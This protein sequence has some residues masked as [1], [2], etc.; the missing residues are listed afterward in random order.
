M[1]EPLVPAVEGPLRPLLPLLPAV[2]EPVALSRPDEDGRRPLE[3]SGSDEPA[4]AEAPPALDPD[5]KELDELEDDEDEDE[6][7]EED[8]LEDADG[9][10]GVGMLV[11]DCVC[12]VDSQALSI[13]AL[14][15]M[16]ITSL[17]CDIFM[18]DYSACH[19]QADDVDYLIRPLLQRIIA[20]QLKRF[21]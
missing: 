9:I 8:E 18:F 5:G 14:R 3:K 4:D 20:L 7:L 10:D 11:L 12:V 1:D 15:P 17:C 6:E 13:R 16:A 21:Q 2:L 19:R